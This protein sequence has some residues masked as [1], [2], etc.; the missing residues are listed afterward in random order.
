[1]HRRIALLVVLLASSAFAQPATQPTLDPR[2]KALPFDFTGPFAIAS[3]GAIVAVRDD[4]ALI[5]RDKG[6]TWEK[7]TILDRAKFTIRQEYAIVRTKSS[8][9]V[10]VFLNGVEQ[11]WKWDAKTN[12]ISGE[13]IL[14]VYVIRSTDNGKTWSAPVK[15]QQGYSGAIRDLIQTSD[16]TL[17][18]PS[19]IFLP[20]KVRH[21]T[22][23]MYSAD[24]GITW[25]T[26]G[27]LDVGGR[28]HHD[29][30]IEACVVER[31]DNSLWMILRTT[32]DVFYE[33]ISKDSGRTWSAP[34]PT[35]ISA[36]SS[37]AMVKRLQSGR[38][39]MAWNQLYPEGKTDYPRRGEQHSEKAASWH[40][41][42]LSI[43]FS[44]DDGKTWSQPQVVAKV[45]K[46]VAY[47]FIVE[48]SPGVIWLTTMQGNLRAELKEAD[49][50]SQ[51]QGTLAPVKVGAPPSNEA[52]T[53]RLPD[54]EMRVFYVH[55][56]EGTEI[57]SI[58]SKDNG[59]T[60]G[61]EQ[62]EFKVPG[63]AYYGVQV[64]LDKNNELQA[65]FHVLGKGDKGYN[66]R[67]YD[68]WHV[69]TSDGRTRWGE[70]KRFFEGYVG[71]IRGF[72]TL[73]TGRLLL[74]VSIAI[75]SRAKAVPGE[76]DYGW[77]DA[78]VFYSDD[79]GD[80][81]TQGKDYLMILQDEA[82]GKTRYGAVEPHVRELLDGRV[83]MLIRTKNGNLWESFSS[84]YGMTW[85][86]PTVSKFISSDSPA[87]TVRLK[88]NRL[89]LLLNACQ[90]WDDVR[91]YAIGGR[92]ILHAA[93]SSDD[94]KT[95]RGFREILRDDQ[96]AEKGDRGTGYPTASETADGRVLVA[97]GQGEGKRALLLFDPNWLE[98]KA[99]CDDFASG[100][101][102]WTSYEGKGVSVIALPDGKP[103]MEIHQVDASTAA[104]AIWNFPAAQ[105]GT[106]QMRVMA[107]SGA[108]QIIASLTDHY[109][110]VSDT[111]AEKNSVY[112]IDLA[113]YLSTDTWHD[114]ELQSSAGGAM[115]ITVDGKPVGEIP[116]QRPSA[117]GANYLRLK[118]FDEAGFVVA[119]VSMI[120]P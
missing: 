2:L 86:Q 73:S 116:A 117:F 78:V 65:V 32:H 52:V 112:S 26:A 80:T 120:A 33:S 43:A 18:L 58:S 56:P 115:K 113:S 89:V 97:S 104:G 25:H 69:K 92:H 38:L 5:S 44:D 30:S 34:A 62:T 98:E 12:N 111:L 29:G 50:V 87:A 114:V 64:T 107:K 118:S 91:N 83:W 41:E 66:G 39:M 57:R 9:L 55:R 16:G 101:S 67:H 11:K 24:D 36:S 13:A 14:P 37:P 46:W 85:N 77:N 49:F 94:G 8:A 75:P 6:A 42:E 27:L 74:S 28:G 71:S 22:V 68:L 51:A 108:K 15:I 119:K 23:P 90:K 88:D 63:A 60:W 72:T 95:W 45:K 81:W 106:M 1:M 76:P 100:D 21:A 103:A 17:V 31:K 105:S 47:P 102:Q 59:R 53:L 19:Q 79:E 35:A 99:A 61:E 7:T 109:C 54:G 84:D 20:D 40:R 70:P 110:V 48:I 4:F 3:D 96:S 10:C 82:R 93:I